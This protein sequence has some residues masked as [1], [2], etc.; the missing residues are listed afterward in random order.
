[1]E[2]T[3]RRVVRAARRENLVLTRVFVL[4]LGHV[5]D[6]LIDDDPEAVGLLA[7]RRNVVFGKRF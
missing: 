3:V 2:W 4:E 1:M 5:V 6:V 7:M